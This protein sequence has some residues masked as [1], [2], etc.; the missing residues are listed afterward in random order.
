MD[1]ATLKKHGMFV[2]DFLR[3]IMW[4]ATVDVPFTR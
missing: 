3:K 2:A 4:F 1:L